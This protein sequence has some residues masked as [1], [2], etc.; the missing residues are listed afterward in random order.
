[1]HDGLKD[2]D[3]LYVVCT[4]MIWYF[5]YTESFSG[6]MILAVHPCNIFNLLDASQA[7]ALLGIA[8]T[9]RTIRIEIQI[10]Q[11]VHNI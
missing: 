8:G 6:S 3:Y 2:L 4:G 10:S 9:K 5:L 1:M 11:N 7:G